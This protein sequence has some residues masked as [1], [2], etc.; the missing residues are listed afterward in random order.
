MVVLCGL[1]VSQR[2]GA[3]KLGGVFGP[4][5]MTYFLVIGTLG[6]TSIALLGNWGVFKV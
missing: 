2:F 5:M 6:L 1:F 3:G 4:I